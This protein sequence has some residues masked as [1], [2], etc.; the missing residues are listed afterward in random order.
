MYCIYE[1]EYRRMHEVRGLFVFILP[2]VTFPLSTIST[3]VCALT[4]CYEIHAWHC[5]II[6][7]QLLMAKTLQIVFNFL[8][9]VDEVS[10]SPT[11]CWL[12]TLK[13]DFGKIIVK[14]ITF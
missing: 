8:G 3:F 6:C 9:V 4:P 11:G 5:Y 12:V 10:H 2:I 13:D 14:L 1:N 7:M